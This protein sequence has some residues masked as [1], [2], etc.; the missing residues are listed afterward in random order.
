MTDHD[1]SRYTPEIDSVHR[2]NATEVRSAQV[3]IVELCGYGE[4]DVSRREMVDLLHMITP[5][6]VA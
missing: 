2:L 4:G 6:G 3:T 5:D 1:S